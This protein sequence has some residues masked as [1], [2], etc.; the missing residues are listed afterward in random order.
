MKT[1]AAGIVLIILIGIAGFFYRTVS[2]T[3]APEVAC[4]AEARICPDGSSVGRSGPTCSFTPC[5]YPNVEIPEAQISFAVPVDYTVDENAVGAEPTLLAAFVKPSL[6]GTPLH[7]I[8]VRRYEIPE[9]QTGDDVILANTRYQPADM[10]AE[11]FERFETVVMS[12]RTF[13]GTVIER[14]EA[15]VSSAYFLVRTDDV[16]RF[17]IVEHD[18]VDWMEPTL[19]IKKLPEHAALLHMLGTLQTP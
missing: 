9:G 8:T 10:N 11:N 16:L 12:G 13:R 17:D 19:A 15:I 4:T 2:E 6:S 7:T 3:T 5:A 18:V 14:F 1:L